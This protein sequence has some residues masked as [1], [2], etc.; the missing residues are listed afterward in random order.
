MALANIAFTDTFDQWRIKTNQLIDAYGRDFVKFTSNTSSFKLTNPAGIGETVF[1]DATPSQNVYDLNST[2][3]AGI[4]VVGNTYG[5]AVA[6]FALANSLITSTNSYSIQ[7]GAAGNTW[8][9]VVGIAG[10]SYTIQI[11]AASNTWANA[12]NSAI[13]TKFPAVN[14]Y[15]EQIGAASNVWANNVGIAG[16]NYTI[17]VGAAANTWANAVGIAGN[18][19]TIQVGAAANGWGN[20]INT[21]IGLRLAAGNAYAVQVGAASNVWANAVGVAGNSY[22]IQVGAASN[23][24][25]NAVGVAG[26][27]YTNSV[28]LSG[29]NYTNAVGVAGNNYSIQ[30]GAAA[31]TWANTKLANTSGV[32]FNG[33]LTFTGNIGVG[34]AASATYPFYSSRNMASAFIGI[35]SESNTGLAG[36]RSINDLGVAANYADFGM[37]G[38]GHSLVPN[39]A[40]VW[41]GG[42]TSPNLV[43]RN[44][45]TEI[46]KLV[47]DG[48]LGLGVVTPTT[49]LDIAGS[50]NVSNSIVV[51]GVNVIPSFA[52]V[53]AWAN[54]ITGVLY[55][56]ANTTANS[57]NS[58]S[59]IANAAVNIY[60]DNS[61][62]SNNFYIPFTT[63]SSG[64]VGY[65]NVSTTKLTF[66]PNSGAV[67]ATHFNSLSDREFKDNIIIITD[68]INKVE[69]MNGYSFTWKD[70]GKPS[71]G[72]IAQ[73]IEAIVPEL[74]NTVNGTKS[75]NYDGIIAFL[76]ESVKELNQRITELEKNQ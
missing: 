21:S 27:N 58:L 33:D 75:V 63:A 67:T 18:N 32:T 44:A 42:T 55:A 22:A 31:N 20:T 1:L 61:T 17:Q 23:V 24:W 13:Q 39:T 30:V 26:N 47:N 29:N 56:F 4:R 28:G 50:V 10:N 59:V 65:M 43:I 6:A 60:T 9:N 72:V 49:K 52:S 35:R 14:S 11:G 48:R 5:H 68:S 37:G 38:S 16:N 51:A 2:N 45:T 7:I 3:V 34:V 53:N 64:V 19:Y 70:N 62:D 57:V 25:A 66:N 76:I 8:A 46:F 54:G 74:V 36:L 71:Y 41:L 69:R 73:E 12:V 15:S 40:F